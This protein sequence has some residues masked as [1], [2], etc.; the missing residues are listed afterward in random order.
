[1]LIFFFQISV[2]YYVASRILTTDLCVVPAILNDLVNIDLKCGQQDAV[3]RFWRAA[4]VQEH[5]QT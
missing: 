4:W 1:M 5:G 2:Q 3:Q